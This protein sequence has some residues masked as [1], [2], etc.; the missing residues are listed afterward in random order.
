MLI[1][2]INDKLK[3]GK[4]SNIRLWTVIFW[5]LIWQIA[6]VLIGQE[7]LLVS[8]V[9]VIVRLSELVTELSFW[10]SILFSFQRIVAGF[11]MAVF[12]GVILASLS[13][14]SNRMR[15][16]LAPLVAVIKATPVA[17]FII[18]VLIW[19]PSRNLSVFISFLMVF[20]II[21]SNVLEG[22]KRTDPKLI[23]MA[24]I[25]SISKWRRF[26]FIYV[27]QVMP[28]FR[29]ACSIGLGLC[30]KSGIAA[31]VIGIPK[32]SIGENLY[33]AKIYLDTPD[34]YA[35]TLV[36]I[37]IS[38]LFEWIFLLGLDLAVKRIERM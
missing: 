33:T 12:F 22:I 2:T 11:I 17:S 18:L 13:A 9:S 4:K 28:F 21:Y 1:S 10:E 34:L 20:P 19:I 30:W 38:L 35:W 24:D 37:L 5:L 36:I 25:F 32:G 7:I 14:Y 3:K 16:L 31:E 15:E 27:S 29:V 6:S 26:C 23:E 8:P